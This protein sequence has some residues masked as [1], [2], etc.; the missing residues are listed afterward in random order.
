VDEIPAYSVD[1][2]DTTGAGDAFIG[3]LLFKVLH[4][5]KNDI[6]ITTIEKEDF[7][8]IIRFA[9]ACGALT[10]TRKGVIPALPVA[11]EVEEFIRKRRGQNAKG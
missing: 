3:G 5:I 10:V 1:A 4:R 2:V 8:N 9:H 7:H 11:S 6:S